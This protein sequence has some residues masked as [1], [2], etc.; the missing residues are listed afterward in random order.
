MPYWKGRRYNNDTL[1]KHKTIDKLKSLT[2]HDTLIDDAGIEYLSKAVKLQELGIISNIV[3]DRSLEVICE[4]PSL[5]SLFVFSAP[6]ITD[7]GVHNLKRTNQLRE[8]YIN[9]TQMT[10][11]GV[12][13]IVHL[14][15]IWS[16]QLQCKQITDTGLRQLEHLEKLR[17]I[18]LDGSRITGHSF[19]E[20]NFRE[21]VHIYVNECPV[22]N[23]GVKC[24]L[25]SVDSPAVLSLETLSLCKTLVTDEIIPEI[26]NVR[27]LSYLWLSGT[28]VTDKGVKHL[29]G[30]PSLSS[31][32]LENTSVSDELVAELKVSSPKDPLCV[33]R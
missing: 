15:D 31:L 16:L 5:V 29:L 25:Q 8:L 27:S 24:I 33:Y 12:A 19:G 1:R 26:A 9:D 23:E 2:I 21:R 32:Y 6:L 18:A 22:D 28:A 11:S 13:S 10:D 3:T 20:L 7:A 14:H 17:I 4:L 30:H